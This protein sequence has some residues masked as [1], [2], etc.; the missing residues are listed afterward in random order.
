MGTINQLIKIIT[1][2][3]FLN[4]FR[5]YCLITPNIVKYFKPQKLY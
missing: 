1:I 5:F 3:Q 2:K 4:L